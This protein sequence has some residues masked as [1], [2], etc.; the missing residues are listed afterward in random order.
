MGQ[1]VKAL[2]N[3]SGAPV[4]SQSGPLFFTIGIVGCNILERYVDDWFKIA[5]QTHPFVSERPLFVVKSHSKLSSPYHISTA[6]PKNSI[7]PSMFISQTTDIED[8]MEDIISMQIQNASP[9]PFP[10][11][12]TPPHRRSLNR[13]PPRSLRPRRQRRP[14]S[15]RRPRLPQRPRRLPRQCNRRRCLADDGIWTVY[16]FDCA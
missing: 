14:R 8:I 12:S 4:G 7:T 5:A 6:Y 1:L 10:H 2:N 16:A 15:P 9:F 11:V 3:G 13:K